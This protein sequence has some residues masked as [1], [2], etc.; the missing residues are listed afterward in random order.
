M[1]LHTRLFPAWLL[2]CALALLALSACNNAPEVTDEDV[3]VLDHVQLKELMTEEPEVLLV[4]VRPDYRYRLGHLPGAINIP[5]PD[6]AFTDQRFAEIKHVVV[7]GDGHRNALS[8][9]AAKKL[10]A[11]GQFLVSDFRGGYEM[12]KRAEGPIVAGPKPLGGS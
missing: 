6:L 12:W 7:Y 1:C 10:L 2:I 5:L 8:H 11:G 3:A 4:D 9:A